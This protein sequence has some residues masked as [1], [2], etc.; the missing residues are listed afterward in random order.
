MK[1]NRTSDELNREYQAILK[2]ISKWR[3]KHPGH[4][5]PL[6]LRMKL[7]AIAK[8]QAQLQKDR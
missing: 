5:T 4:D 7:D 1:Q 3:I 2:E 6:W 8:R